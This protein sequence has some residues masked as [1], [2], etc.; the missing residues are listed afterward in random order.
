ML[1]QG[2]SY[3]LE[4]EEARPKNSPSN[5]VMKQKSLEL[6]LTTGRHRSP[7]GSGL[8]PLEWTVEDLFPLP[9]VNKPFLVLFGSAS[10][11]S[12]ASDEQ[13]NITRLSRTSSRSCSV[14][15]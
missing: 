4:E 8:G 6:R 12:R 1:D 2:L 13:Q 11:S 10:L 3:S 5:D 9:S 14:L 15:R 7:R